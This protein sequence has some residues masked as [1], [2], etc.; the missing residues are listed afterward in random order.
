MRLPAFFKKKFVR[1]LFVGGINTLFSYAI[2]ALLLYVGLQYALANFLAMLSGIFF[3][4]QTQGRLVFQNSDQSLIWRYALF[5]FVLYLCNIV[6]IKLMLMGG[7]DAYSAGALAFPVI[8]VLS[9]FMQ[10]M[11]VFRVRSS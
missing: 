1:F 2:Y 8:V 10:K 4:F 11:L 6:L 7:V 9:F 5:W 3:S